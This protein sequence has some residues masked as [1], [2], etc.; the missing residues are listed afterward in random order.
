MHA[1]S[2]YVPAYA[3]LSAVGL[4]MVPIAAL[5]PLWLTIVAALAAVAAIIESVGGGVRLRLHGPLA[6]LL[7]TIIIW[8]AAS[9]IWS[10]VPEQSVSRAFRLFLFGAGFL[11]L[12]SA[13]LRID[14]AGRRR[15]ES[16]LVAGFVIGLL[17]ILFELATSGFV[18]SALNGSYNKLNGQ[19]LTRAMNL[20]ELNRASSVISIMA[21]VAVIPVWRRFGWVG[22]FA[23][24]LVSG[25][26]I[27]QLQ[28]GS[29]FLAILAG[30]TLFAIAWFM[31]RLATAALV[32]AIAIG[33]LML[34]FITE[35]QPI[36]TGLIRNLGFSEFSLNHRMAIWQFAS[37][38]SLARPV[39]G[40]GLDASRVVGVGQEVVVDDAPNLRFRS[41]DVLPLHP[42][43]AL[44][45][46]WLELGAIGALLLGALFT[47][48]VFAIRRHLRGRLEHA[49]ASAAFAA[50][51]VNA[52]LSFGIWQ[53]WWLSCLALVVVLIAALT[54]A[55]GADHFPETT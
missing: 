45:Q 32:A 4:L 13:A 29:P 54:A 44:L 1:L 5:E 17:F 11:I 39:L 35:L 2:R 46:A 20:F 24:V 51:F 41:V 15:L 33:L 47:S 38:H 26:A 42:H 21:W 52:E 28:P 3:I 40:W 7:G 36:I 30:A 10:I 16:F 9:A 49:A 14:P 55:T 23:V 27:S 34:P 43:N 37:E 50:A 19:P 22:A 6:W 8:G 48:A 31:P 53:G 18:H 12:F 25:F